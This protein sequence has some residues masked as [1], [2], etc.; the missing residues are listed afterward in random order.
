[1][2]IYYLIQMH[3]FKDLLREK[4]TIRSPI[5]ENKKKIKMAT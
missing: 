5:K 4:H 1:M 3:N 2:R